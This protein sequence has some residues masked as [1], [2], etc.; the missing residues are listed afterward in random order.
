MISCRDSAGVVAMADREGREREC[1]VDCLRFMWGPGLVLGVWASTELTCYMWEAVVRDLPLSRGSEA[2]V[3]KWCSYLSTT[4]F[5]LEFCKL[6][7]SC[8]V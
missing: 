5:V 3:L 8:Q 1:C 6:V 4:P 2:D 7:V